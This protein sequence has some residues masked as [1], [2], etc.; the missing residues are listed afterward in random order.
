MTVCF[1]LGESLRK[2]KPE[3]L[4]DLTA[5]SKQNILLFAES[6]TQRR[7]RTTVLTALYNM[8]KDIKRSQAAAGHTTAATSIASAYGLE[9]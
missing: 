3:C 1:R 5:T 4:L 2:I 8:T 7:F 6:I 9:N